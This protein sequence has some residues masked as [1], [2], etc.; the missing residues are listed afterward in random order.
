MVA[1][2]GAVGIHSGRHFH[3]ATGA[4]SN[5]GE[6]RKLLESQGLSS[7]TRVLWTVSHFWGPRDDVT[8]PLFHGEMQG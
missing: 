2:V 7:L 8:W 6:M 1:G 3:E 5:A 4:K